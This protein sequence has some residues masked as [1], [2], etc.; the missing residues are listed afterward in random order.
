MIFGRT[1]HFAQWDICMFVHMSHWK[2]EYV[3]PD[4]LLSRLDPET[5]P[6]RP[7]PRS[8]AQ[9]R[10]AFAK[11]EGFEIIA[12]FTEVE[13]GKGATRSTAAAVEG[14]AEGGEEGEV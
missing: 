7:W 8:A 4:R 9:G 10:A 11:A 3:A 2:P 14:G 5:G 13:T 12:E 6:F 1:L